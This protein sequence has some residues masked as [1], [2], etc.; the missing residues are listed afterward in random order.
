VLAIGLA[1]L[2]GAVG[3]AHLSDSKYAVAPAALPNRLNYIV[4]PRVAP[5]EGL[6][7]GAKNRR[8]KV[9]GQR[10]GKYGAKRPISSR[11]RARQLRVRARRSRAPAAA[12]Q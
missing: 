10:I 9:S 3:V 1:A 6:G 7:A 12:A 5:L 11:V 2:P 4:F 8:Q